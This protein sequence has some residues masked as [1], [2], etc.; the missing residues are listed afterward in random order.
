[1]IIYAEGPGFD[2][3]ILHF[4]IFSCIS[5]CLLKQGVIFATSCYNVESFF[6][7]LKVFSVNGR[8]HGAT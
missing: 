7:H 2:H 1:M 6:L 5:Q 4:S 3:P 8:V